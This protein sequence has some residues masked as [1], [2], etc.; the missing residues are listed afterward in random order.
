MK[1]GNRADDVT[2]VRLNPANAAR[3][4][5]ATMFDHEVD[6]DQLAAFVADP[7]HEMVV[8]ISREKAVG[9]ASGAIL[10]HPDKQPVFFVSEVGV[11]R[12]FRRRGI[13]QALMLQLINIAR[14]RGCKGI[15]LATEP[16]NKAARAL[17]RSL[18]GRA[19][20]NIVV[21]DWDGAM[22]D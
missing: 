20:E 11:E 3:M 1:P 2:Y 7:N 5:G 13:G 15:W 16:D 17:Y 8:A 10:L 18:K 12:G 22:D 21:Y 19:T 6:A 4:T 14:N 9:F